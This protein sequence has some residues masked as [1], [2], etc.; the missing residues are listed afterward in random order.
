MEDSDIL[1]AVYVTGLSGAESSI[2]SVSRVVGGDLETV[3]G[4]LE[5]AEKEGY[6]EKKGSAVSLTPK[7]RK[8]LAVVMIGG[9]F[10]IIHP[11]HIHTISEARRYGDTLVVVVAADKTVQKNKGRE[12]V[13]PQEWRVKL[14]GSLRDVDLSLAG[15]Q[16]S[17]Y[18]TLEK[19]RPDVVALGYDQKHN[20][21]EI[22]DE[23]AKR[24]LRVKVVRLTSPIPSVKTSKI[25]SELGV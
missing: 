23:A 8:E 19:V 12:P 25:V 15:G 18:E 3:W 22:E 1:R 5:E 9:A 11:G 13:T 10:E 24:G 20:P 14:I 21:K 6:V 2:E 17:I 16:G 4:R 7:G